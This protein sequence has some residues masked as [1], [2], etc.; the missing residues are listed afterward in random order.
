MFIKKKKA[1]FY[2][3]SLWSLILISKARIK[4]MLPL[5]ELPIFYSVFLFYALFYEKMHFAS[6]S[7][8]GIFFLFLL[9][10]A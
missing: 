2:Y 6:Q 9:R 4:I 1:I 5:F 7:V 8:G 3:V 10:K